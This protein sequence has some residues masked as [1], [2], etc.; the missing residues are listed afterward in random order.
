MHD[1]DV[2]AFEMRRPWPR[3]D[4]FYDA[5]PDQ[6][7]WSA[8]RTFTL[9]GRGFRWPSFI[10]V[11]HQEPGG[12]DCGEVCKHYRRWQDDTGQWQTKLLNGWRWH[13][14]HW[15][16]QV[17]PAQELRRRLLTRCAWCGGRHRKRDPVNVSNQWDGP[18]GRWWQ[19]EPNLFHHDCSMVERV[20]RMCLCADPGLNHGDY[21]QCAFCGKF[22]AYRSEPDDAD[23]MLA[24][25]TAGSRIPPDLCPALEAA[26]DERRRRREEAS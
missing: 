7:R 15:H 11:W 21:G 16:L 20:H 18:R 4:R 5:K 12:R 14:H 3:R 23:R 9:A 19:G 1:P 25:L 24:A 26:W 8:G 2:V 22:R 10:T 13:I 6:P 17:H